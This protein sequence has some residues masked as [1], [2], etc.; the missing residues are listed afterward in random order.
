MTYY[1]D[2]RY[3]ANQQTLKAYKSQATV[4][5]RV[6]FLR[7][8]WESLDPTPGSATNER[9]LDH[10]LRMNEANWRFSAGKRR[11]GIDTDR[12]RILVQYGPPEDTI[13][14]TSAAG[15]RPYE[16]WVY[17][18]DRRYDFV[19][20]DLKGLGVYEL[21]H[22]TYPGELSNPYWAQVF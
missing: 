18:E 7:T 19:F 2:I 6:D 11:K 12:G 4:E 15:R 5:D 13:Y 10:V 21:V 22:S 8:F 14:R 1:S 20:R 9:L 3:V 17:E 16:V